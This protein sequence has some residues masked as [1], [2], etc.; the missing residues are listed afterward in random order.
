MIT[1]IMSPVSFTRL[2]SLVLLPR[3]LL[4]RHLSSRRAGLRAFSS[5]HIV[6]TGVTNKGTTHMHQSSSLQRV[7][8][9][10]VLLT[11]DGSDRGR[12]RD[13]KDYRATL[14]SAPF[15]MSSL[16]LRGVTFYFATPEPRAEQL[17]H[18]VADE[19]TTRQENKIEE[20]HVREILPCVDNVY[21]NLSFLKASLLL[22][23]YGTGEEKNTRP[24]AT[25]TYLKEYSAN[26]DD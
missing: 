3:E 12:K 4:R 2:Q 6:E 18:N 15:S 8:V 10:Q 26:S 13:G 25:T 21:R 16:P 9:P 24:S 11:P 5:V 14:T 19:L 17:Q 7:M 23:K 20:L 22:H 1:V